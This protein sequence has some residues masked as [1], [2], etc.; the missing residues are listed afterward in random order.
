MSESMVLSR[1]AGAAAQLMLLFHGVGS[2]PASMAPLGERLAAA[3]PHACIVSIAAP[4][5]CDLGAGYQWFSVRDISEENRPQRVAQAMPAFEQV[6]R[7]WQR[8]SGAGVEQTALIGFSQGGI[9][10]LESTRDRVAPAGRVVALGGRWAL[11]PQ[12]ANDA[13]TLY[14]LHGRDDRVIPYQATIEAARHLVAL[15]ADLS[16]DVLPGIGHSVDAAM[17]ELLIERLRSHVPQR[18]WREA[19]RADQGA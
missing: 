14:M 2:A 16:A 1:P 10:A 19:L 9:M 13:V 7:H 3:F 17:V 4:D 5:A 11:L 18:L 12:R 15:G 8:E 6:I